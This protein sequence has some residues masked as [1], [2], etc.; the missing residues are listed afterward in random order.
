MSK[1]FSKIIIAVIA[2]AFTTFGTCDLALASVWDKDTE[3]DLT[4]NSVLTVYR[5]PNCGCCGKWLEHVR[6]NG[7]KV[8]DIKT[9]EMTALKQKYRIPSEL[10]SCHTA[11]VN[12]YVIEGHVP[13]E[14]IKRFLAENPKANS[15]ESQMTGLTVPGMVIGSPGMEEKDIKQPFQILAFNNKGKIAVFNEY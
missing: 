9:E 2:I 8:R 7:F 12:G 11:I 3:V 6:D 15:D 5:S 1:L 4:A 10:T 13:A 14:D